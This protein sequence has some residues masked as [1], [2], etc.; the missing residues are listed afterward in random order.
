MNTKK[1]QGILFLKGKEGISTK[2]IQR[3]LD[4]SNKE[5]KSLIEELRNE[6]IAKDQPFIIKNFENIY[7][8]SLSPEISVEL[9][10]NMKKDI[11]VRLTKSL[12]ETLTI[13]AYNQPVIKSDVE[14]IRGS[15]ADYALVKLLNYDLIEEIGRDPNKV[16][17]PRLFA[18]TP[19]FLILFD[20]KSLKDL[21]EMERDFQEKTEEI[22]LLNYED[23]EEFYEED[24]E[25][26]IERTSEEEVNVE[27]TEEE[28]KEF[29]EAT[30]E[31]EIK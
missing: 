24:K 12:I 1:L 29:D 9:A 17:N 4:I 13:I 8:I 30:K 3:I 27:L 21:P 25:I 19:Y 10:K 31:I 26:E 15:S 16:G 22:Q 28:K 5:V 14:K 11:K 7:W 6:M 20:L 2:E 18:T 23:Q